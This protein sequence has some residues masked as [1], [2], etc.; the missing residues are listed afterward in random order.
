MGSIRSVD[1]RLRQ[2]GGLDLQLLKCQGP[3]AGVVVHTCCHI[4]PETEARDGLSPGVADQPGPHSKTS[5]KFA[6]FIGN[7]WSKCKR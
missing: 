6:V 1:K 7:Y 4:A 5:M 2:E 3:K